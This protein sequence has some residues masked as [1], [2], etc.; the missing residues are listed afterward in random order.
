M[1][2]ILL[3][4]PCAFGLMPTSGRT[5]SDTEV[6]IKGRNSS[7]KSM[8]FLVWFWL[9]WSAG[10]RFGS[11]NA[12]VTER[13]DSMVVVLAP[14]RPDLRED[15]RV[16]VVLASPSGKPYC[17][18]RSRRGTAKDSR[19]PVQ[20]AWRTIPDN[21][22]SEH[23][24]NPCLNQLHGNCFP[25]GAF[26]GQRYLFSLERYLPS[27]WYSTV[28]VQEDPLIK[29]GTMPSPPA[30][31]K[32]HAGHPPRRRSL[33][34]TGALAPGVDAL[35]AIFFAFLR[36]VFLHHLASHLSA[37]IAPRADRR[38][39]VARHPAAVLWRIGQSRI[40]GSG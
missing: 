5:D 40:G 14:P 28:G 29:D 37:R 10:C 12:K 31:P 20:G 30:E 25:F 1:N 8:L 27:E 2:E 16:E 15:T 38:H 11:H 3:I 32:R 23:N 21:H 33:G 39:G 18:R 19:F 9:Y 17:V 24:L 13:N 26:K 34:Q 35:L 22:H 7:H 6:W 36:V 4:V